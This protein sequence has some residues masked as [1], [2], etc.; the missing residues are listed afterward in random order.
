MFL[1]RSLR[2]HP[3]SMKPRANQSS[4]SGWVGGLPWLPK[5]SEVETKPRP[6]IICQYRLTVTR[7]SNGWSGEVSQR[8]NP[9]RFSFG[10]VSSFGRNSGVSDVTTLSRS[11]YSPR[12]RIWVS[13]FPG[14]SFITMISVRRW[15]WLPYS[16]RVATK[17]I[18]CVW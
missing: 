6:K 10:D 17:A 1:N 14:I 9:K 11:E 4:N 8:A 13:R 18:F 12:L 3:E 7:A 16:D 15:R 2:S 5:S